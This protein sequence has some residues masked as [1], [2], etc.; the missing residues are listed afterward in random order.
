MNRAP[1]AMRTKLDCF[2]CFLR[3]GLQTARLSGTNDD[4]LQR[5]MTRFLKILQDL[6]D[7]ES[8]LGVT[9]RIQNLI[10][11]ET[12]VQDPY[13]SVKNECTREAEQYLSQL[14]SEVSLAPAPL[15]TALKLAVIGNVMDY[16]A[17]PLFKLGSLTRRLNTTEFTVDATGHFIS[18]LN[19]ARR[20]A[21]IADNTGEIVFDSILIERLLND[22]RIEALHLVIR[23]EPFLNDVSDERHIPD[24]LLHNPRVKIERLSVDPARR[25]EAVWQS[26]IACDIVLNKGMANFENYADQPGFFFLLI[27]KCK[28]VSDLIAARVQHP[29]TTGDWIFL[30]QAKEA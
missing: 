13:L 15:D 30:H 4:E 17:D 28:L 19:S 10:R 23:D 14:N 11:K 18:E 1:C 9:S 8:P 26:V 3:T 5:L 16:G 22:Y 21:Y 12:G 2:S 29:V 27:S 7:K 6:P 25:N 20:M 24:A